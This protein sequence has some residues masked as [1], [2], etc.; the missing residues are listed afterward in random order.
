MN[1]TN[2]NDLINNIQS[3]HTF[4]YNNF[5]TTYLLNN[6]QER[7]VMCACL[8]TNDH[9]NSLQTITTKSNFMPILKPAIQKQITV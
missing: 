4:R 1:A 3:S 9:N 6:N 5:V 8:R 2:R 7:L